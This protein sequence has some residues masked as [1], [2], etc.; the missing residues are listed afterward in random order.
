MRTLIFIA[1]VAFAGMA[2]ADSAV[3]K[4]YSLDVKER[5]QT[6][7]LIDVTAEKPIS[8]EAESPCPRRTGRNHESGTHWPYSTKMESPPWAPGSLV[9]DSTDA[10]AKVQPP[11]AVRVN[12]N[13]SA[14]ISSISDGGRLTQL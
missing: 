8:E 6:L 9:S 5:I 7:E 12:R 10:P 3:V 2:W 13:V 14:L 11:T 1:T 4:V